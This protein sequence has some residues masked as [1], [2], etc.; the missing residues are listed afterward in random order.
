MC[1]PSSLKESNLNTKGFEST[2]DS[3]TIRKLPTNQAL[4]TRTLCRWPWWPSLSLCPD[5]EV[6]KTLF[7]PSHPT[8]RICRR[9]G[10]GIIPVRMIKKVLVLALGHGGASSFVFHRWP[11][12]ALFV[13]YWSR[14]GKRRGGPCNVLRNGIHDPLVKSKRNKPMAWHSSNLQWPSIY[15]CIYIYISFAAKA[16]EGTT[17]TWRSGHPLL[18]SLF[19]H[20]LRCLCNFNQFR[21]GSHNHNSPM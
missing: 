20:L 6:V 14:G 21:V 2:A 15:I 5:A 18:Q 19:T 11:C 3:T 7:T 9:R 12:F 17:L 16:S 13:R 10:V 1:K 8:T 4:E